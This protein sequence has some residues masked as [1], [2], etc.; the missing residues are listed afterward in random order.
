M[1]LSNTNSP[2]AIFRAV[3]SYADANEPADVPAAFADEEE[4]SVIGRESICIKES[5]NCWSIL[6]EGFIQRKTPA[7]SSPKPRNIRT[8]RDF[9]EEDGF[10]DG[11]SDLAAPSPVAANAWPVLDW[12]VTVFELDETQQVNNGLRELNFSQNSPKYV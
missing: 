11:V 1:S 2:G 10:L 4:D 12:M 3:P 9:L 6:K 7:I 5:K 8:R